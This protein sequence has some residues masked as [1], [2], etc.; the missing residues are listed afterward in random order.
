MK[1]FI[2]TCLKEY[3]K[4]VSDIF[5]QA[6]ISVFSTSD[7]VG[8]KD[9]HTSNLLDDWFASGPEQFD[10]L[11]IFSFT[12]DANAD[13]ALELIE[14]Y[15]QLYNRDFPVR[16]FIVPVEKTNFKLTQK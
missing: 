10:S 2:T 16:A 11:M 4:E 14:A 8:S 5:K 12:S 3:N 1:L 6:G 13:R 7:I 9:G 15:N